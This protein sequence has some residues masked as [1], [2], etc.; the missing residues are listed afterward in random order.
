MLPAESNDL[1][2]KHPPAPVI[3]VYKRRWVIL[4]IFILYS[5]ANAFQW[6]EYSII[7]NIVVKFYRVSTIAVDWTSIIYMVIY[8]FI[9]VPASYII[10]TQGLRVTA[11]IGGLGTALAAV[12]KVFS[13]RQD[14]FRL[15]LL[16]QAIGSTAQVFVMCL[17]AKIAAVWFSPSEASLACSLA[18]FGTQLGFALG[19]VLP[20]T[21]VK[22]SEDL[23]VIGSGLQQLCWVLAIYMIPVSVAI[24]FYFPAQPPLPPSIA[25]FDERKLR[26]SSFRDFWN[27]FT[28]SLKHYGF[29]LHLAAYGINVGVY[30]GFGTFLNQ[31]VVHFF[32]HG[33]EDAG[34]MGLLAVVFG[35]IGSILLGIFLDKTHRYK[36][37]TLFVYCMAAVGMLAMAGA[38][39]M[40][41]LPLTYATCI[42]AG[43]FF[44]CYM[45]I[46]F[47]LA[48]ELTFPSEES[49]TTGLMNAVTQSMGV[50][51]TLALGKLNHQIGPLLSLVFLGL[52]LVIGAILTQNI[53]NVKRRQDEFEKN[54]RQEEEMLALKA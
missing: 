37:T 35:M 53:P 10:D 46:G 4:A 41:S 14:L 11:L 13:I 42:F 48:V 17:P 36:E 19:F 7:T 12:V 40:R 33:E 25:Q 20:P 39:R 45:P 32:P 50:I 27:K 34:R 22:N 52:F 51:V 26:K 9:V 2:E 23:S 16:G 54:K 29:V 49:T 30:A 8:P 21:L 3:K 6:I 5:C 15:V 1:F 24:I 43:F 44:N 28:N 18:V 31:I 47:E 38:L